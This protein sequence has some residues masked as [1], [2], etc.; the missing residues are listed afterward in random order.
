MTGR[1]FSTRTA[2]VWLAVG[3]SILFAAVGCLAFTQT[4][5]ASPD[6]E[7]FLNAGPDRAVIAAKRKK[8]CRAGNR[9]RCIKTKTRRNQNSKRGPRYVSPALEDG[10][11]ANAAGTQG[12]IDWALAQS[13]RRD[14]NWWC[15]KFVAH[16]FGMSASG[17]NSP[18]AM[19]AARGVVRGSTPPVGSLVLYG[20]VRGNPYGHVGIYLGSGKMINALSTVRITP[21]SGIANYVGWLPAPSHW[22]GR[23]PSNPAPAYVAPQP[24]ASTPTAPASGPTRV[25]ITV[26]NKVTN[27]ATQMRED[28]VPVRLTSKPWIYCGSRGC[29]IGGTERSTGGV[30]DAAICWTTGERTTN[31]HD[32]SATDDGN[33]GLYTS[34]RYY[35]VKLT[36][37]VQGYVSWVW[38]NPAHRDGRGLPNC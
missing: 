17:Y 16:A 20:A 5:N 33:P 10:L 13:G 7:D 38:I 34:N 25:P 29:N 8:S 27:G 30:Y 12:A 9:K 1:S 14:Y 3:V 11:G 15:L 24:P 26:H 18:V 22:P 32:G 28:T 37:G 2:A 21:V 35:V 6:L 36:N 4:A 23:P 31:G 19:M